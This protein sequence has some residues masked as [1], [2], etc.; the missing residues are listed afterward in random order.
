M[1]PP[2]E[3]RLDPTAAANLD[4]Y[5][6]EH[7][8]ETEHYRRMV[9]ENPEHAVKTILCRKMVQ[10]DEI[11]HLAVRLR[12]LVEEW[13]SHTPGLHD[14]LMERIKKVAP[15]DSSVAYIEEALRAKAPLV[16]SPAPTHRASGLSAS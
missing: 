5:I 2:P 4:R 3:F 14:R 8:Q 6:A 1:K 10:Q 9:T 15:L 16:L 11:R 13:V 12:P 7:P